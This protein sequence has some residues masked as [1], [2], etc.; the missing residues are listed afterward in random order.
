MDFL[1]EHRDRLASFADFSGKLGA[2]ADYVQG[3]GGDVGQ[4]GRRADGDQTSGFCLSD[5]KPDRLRRAEQRCAAGVYLD[6]DPKPWTMWRLQDH[7][8]PRQLFVKWQGGNAAP[9][10]GGRLSFHSGRVCRT[11]AQRVR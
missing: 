8:L 7:R 5:I 2:R 4:A 3:G 1:T 6:T 9:L 10:G 11:Y